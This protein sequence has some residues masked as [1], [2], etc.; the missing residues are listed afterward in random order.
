MPIVGLDLRPTEENFKAHVGRGTGRYTSELVKHLRELTRDSA[1]PLQLQGVGSKDLQITATEEK[2]L[3]ALPFGRMTFAS[4]FLFPR[5]IRRL[6]LDLIHFFA[7][8][9][10]PAYATVPQLVTVL[11]LI[12]L[13]FPQLYRAKKSNLRFRFARF[14]EYQSIKRSKGVLA[15][16]ESTKHDLINLLGVEEKKIVVTPL[17]VGTEFFVEHERQAEKSAALRNQLGLPQDRP[18]L[19]YVGG[20]DPRKNVPFLVDVF[21]E[22]LK[23][24]SVNRPILA[25]AGA[26]AKDDQYPDLLKKIDLL[27]L[28]QEV[29]LLGFVPDSDLPLLY[30]AADIFLFPSL[31]EGFGFPVLE[32]MASGLPVIAGRNSSIPEV[33]GDSALLVQ[34]LLLKE[35][36]DTAK[37]L[38][39]NKERQREL[40]A[41][42][43]ARAKRFAWQRSAERTLDAYR[44]FIGM[45]DSGRPLEQAHRRRGLAPG[46]S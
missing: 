35:W 18:L 25:L 42:G 43:K 31:Y 38:L 1:S 3:K 39:G 37:E 44:L 24:S 10:A 40:G 21:A 27:G 13:R 12:P 7:H 11:D 34:D 16:S 2:L 19:L 20:I 30:R 9:D 45:K 5:R 17:G 22:L 29:R 4:Q 8:G 41:L 14:L 32:A 36:V 46:L 6:N 15:I 23:H 28:R 33:A 26:Y